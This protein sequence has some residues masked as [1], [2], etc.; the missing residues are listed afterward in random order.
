MELGVWLAAMRPRTWPASLVPVVVGLAVAADARGVD[1][2]IALATLV[3]ALALQITTNLANDYWDH[4]RGIDHGERLGPVR[5]TQSGLLAPEAVRR[6]VWLSLI[7]AFAAGVPLVWRGGAP[8]VLI[9][10]ASML[11]AVMSGGGMP[12]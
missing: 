1:A 7:V 10:L 11:C 3:S 8:I 5:A 4:V 12:A 6:A 9:G 2:P